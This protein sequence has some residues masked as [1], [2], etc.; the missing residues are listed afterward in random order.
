[1]KPMNYWN[2]KENCF[3]EAKK[4][5]TAYEL[6]RSNYGCY[7]G[8]RRNGWVYEA[9]PTKGGVKQMNYW[10]NKDN[11]IDAA[12]KCQT[13]ME[14]KKKFGGAFNAAIRYG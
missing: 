11:V 9:Y 12:K 4:Y 14:F 2:N 8:L 7:Q 5:R 6:Q 1:M 3:K 10:K 13:K